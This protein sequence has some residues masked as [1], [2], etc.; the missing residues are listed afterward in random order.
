MAPKHELASLASLMS[1]IDEQM[2]KAVTQLQR[3]IIVS[4]NTLL[5]H[6][7]LSSSFLLLFLY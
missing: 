3:P 7:A 1:Y 2:Q 4:V 6:T 5:S